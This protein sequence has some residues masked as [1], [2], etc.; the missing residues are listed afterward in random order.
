MY[1]K[2]FRGC[3]SNPLKLL[4][5]PDLDD[6]LGNAGVLPTQVEALKRKGTAVFGEKLF[7]H[8]GHLVHGGQILVAVIADVAF[9][10]LCDELA[11][12][13]MVALGTRSLIHELRSSMSEPF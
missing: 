4:G 12:R 11:A 9:G 6:A 10:G 8:L 5:Q 2:A 13:D 1:G 3:F 7:D